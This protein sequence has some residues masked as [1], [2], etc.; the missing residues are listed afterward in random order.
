MTA[1]SEVQPSAPTPANEGALLCHPRSLYTVGIRTNGRAD[2][3]V[4]V[5]EDALV[6]ALKVK[7]AH[8]DAAI[9]YVRRANRRGDERHPS[10]TLG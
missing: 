9:N 1:L 8:P 4:I 10:H 7:A 5:A 6:A 2:R 3:I